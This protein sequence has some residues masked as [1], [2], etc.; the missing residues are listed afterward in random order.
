M[1]YKLVKNVN[2]LQLYINKSLL[3]VNMKIKIN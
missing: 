3:K 1:L 2:F